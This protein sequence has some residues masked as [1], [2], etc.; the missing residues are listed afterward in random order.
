MQLVVM[1]GQVVLPLQELMVVVGV[2]VMEV[3]Q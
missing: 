3:V 1:E 2:V